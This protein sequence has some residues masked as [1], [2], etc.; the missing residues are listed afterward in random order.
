MTT[1]LLRR[2][3]QLIIIRLPLHKRRL[4]FV[5]T[6]AI[7]ASLVV[8]FPQISYTYSLFYQTAPQIKMLA[9]QP[10]NFNTD[11]AQIEKIVLN[12]LRSGAIVS[13]QVKRITVVD[14]YAMADWS[15]GEAGGAAVLAKKKGNWV[16]LAPGGG[17]YNASELQQMG[18]PENTAKKLLQMR[19]KCINSPAKCVGR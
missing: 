6:G 14:D 16:F 5:V 19:L 13:P 9:Q 7:V 8:T 18:I 12:K 3:N 2:I 4:Y 10:S 15:Q 11:S 17:V 1:K